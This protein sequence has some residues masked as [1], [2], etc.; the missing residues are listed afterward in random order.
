MMQSFLVRENRARTRFASRQ[1][2]GRAVSGLPLAVTGETDPCRA[3]N[4]L[5]AGSEV[6]A[7]SPVGPGPRFRPR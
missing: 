1:E 7:G 5:D 3:M 2:K 4:R 6:Y